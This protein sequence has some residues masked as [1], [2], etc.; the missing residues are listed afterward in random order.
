MHIYIYI[1]TRKGTHTRIH[2]HK[3]TY[4]S[5]HTHPHMRQDENE[6]RRN[7]VCVACAQKVVGLSVC[8]GGGLKRLPLNGSIVAVSSSKIIG[9]C[10]VRESR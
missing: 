10:G 4:T 7:R 1:G 6:N 3:C 2:I 9:H 5:T 8:V